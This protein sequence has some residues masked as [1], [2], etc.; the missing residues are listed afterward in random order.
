M[1]AQVATVGG[2]WQAL[3]SGSRTGS[4]HQGDSTSGPPMTA[5]GIC[6]L[7]LHFHLWWRTTFMMGNNIYSLDKTMQRGSIY[8]EVKMF[9]LFGRFLLNRNTEDWYKLHDGISA[10]RPVKIDVKYSCNNWSSVPMSCA[11]I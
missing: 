2:A 6:A 5:P 7:N 4:R 11:S 9:R 8:F 3:G 10:K 1:L